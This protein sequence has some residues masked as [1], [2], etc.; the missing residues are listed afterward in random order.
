MYLVE[1]M[2]AIEAR[3]G[4]PRALAWEAEFN[5]REYDLLR[6]CLVKGRAHDVTLLIRH[7][8]RFALIRKP[9]YPPGLF[10]P[11]SGGVEPGE[12]FEAG[13]A[14]EAYEETGLAI[15]LTRYLLRFDACFRHGAEATSW[16]TYVFAADAVTR[17]LAV[18]DHK[19][20]AEACWASPAA[21]HTV[22]RPRM[23]AWGSEGMR[24]RV[25]IQDEALAMLGHP[26]V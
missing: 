5:G 24:Y 1:R 22:M 14:R 6:S 8:E 11:P 26:V 13:A 4:S 18:V 16:R 19:E 25:A 15:R 9:F 3:Y 12:A 7:G 23:L 10:R 17:E 20:I 21:I 2:S